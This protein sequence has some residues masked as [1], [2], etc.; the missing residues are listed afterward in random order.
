MHPMLN[1]AIKA[2]RQAGNIIMRAFDH[3]GQIE[4]TPKGRH[5]YVTKVD[6]YAEE[7]IIETL[8]TAY[9]EHG[10]LAEESGEKIGKNP[11]YQWIIDP[12]DGTLNFIN[13]FPHFCVS[14]A[15]KV[16]NK[17]EHGVIYDPVRNELFT[18]SRGGGASLD[19]HRIRVNKTGSIENSFLATGFPVREPEKFESYLESFSSIVQKTADVR[20]AGSAALDLAYVAAGRLDGYW[21][22]GLKIWDVAAGSLMILEAG[23]YV[24]D[25]DGGEEYLAKGD[26][27]GANMKL[28]KNIL[29]EVKRSSHFLK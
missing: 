28:Y 17:I 13:G 6:K 10:V 21:E 15:L 19:S 12:L 3:R 1:T 26:I 2:A 22:S 20:R 4:A 24:G 14:I 27:I 23:G 11:K 5:D 25:H 8:L 29:K 9:P 18:A 7:V 16:G